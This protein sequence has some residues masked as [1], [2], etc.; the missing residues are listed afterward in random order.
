MNC[1]KC[2]GEVVRLTCEG[3]KFF[4]SRFNGSPVRATHDFEVYMCKDSGHSF[5]LKGEEFGEEEYEVCP[6]CEKLTF[7]D[8]ESGLHFHASSD[9]T[10]PYAK[11]ILVDARLCTCGVLYNFKPLFV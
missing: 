7:T 2:G 9:E 5:S 3:G 8:V 1:P 10:V 4:T 11:G 6:K